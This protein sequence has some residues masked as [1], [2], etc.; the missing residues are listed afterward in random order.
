[1]LPFG[2]KA[3]TIAAKAAHAAQEDTGV[4]SQPPSELPGELSADPDYGVSHAR[5]EAAVNNQ[6]KASYSLSYQ[7]HAMHSFFSRE[8]VGLPGF[9]HF[10]KAASDEKREHTHH[11]MHYQTM[12]GRT[13]Q[14]LVL[15]QH[16]KSGLIAPPVTWFLFRNGWLFVYV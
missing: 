15:P 8:S 2:V 9:A 6:I 3:S 12:R 10:F 4:A 16:S 1:M 14:L 11:L 7:Y 13:I 5:L